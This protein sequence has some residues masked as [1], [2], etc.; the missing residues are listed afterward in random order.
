MDS[1]EAEL[2]IAPRALALHT[3]THC[4]GAHSHCM[5][6]GAVTPRSAAIALATLSRPPLLTF[7][8]KAGTMSTELSSAVLQWIASRVAL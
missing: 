3:Q 6:G 5:G 1:W 4:E 8:A 7:P 2:Q